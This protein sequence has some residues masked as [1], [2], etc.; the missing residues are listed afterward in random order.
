MYLRWLGLCVGMIIF[1]A[2]TEITNEV[3]KQDAPKLDRQSTMTSPTKVVRSDQPAFENFIS[4][5]GNR[6]FDGDQPF[7]FI[8]INVPTLLYVEDE[9]TFTETNPIRLPTEFET[10]DVLAAVKEI[11]GQVVRSYS[12]PVRNSSFPED[13]VTY[14]EAPGVFNEDAFQVMDQ[15]VALAGEYDLRLIIPL[16]NNWPW[17]GGRPNYAE[18]RGKDPDAF[19]SDPQLIS[20]FKQT[21]DFVLNRVNTITGVAYKDD[22]TIMAWETGNEMTCPPEW[23]VKI[24]SYLKEVAPQQLTIDGWHAVHMPYEGNFISDYIQPHSINH[25]SIDIVSTHHYEEDPIKMLETLKETVRRVGGKKPIFVGEFGFISTSGMKQVMDYIINEEDIAGGMTWSL[26]RHH[27]NGGWFY[28]TEPLG[29]GLYRAYHWPGFDEG[30][31]YDERD[32]LSA[33]QQSAFEIAG[34]SVPLTEV[35]QAP[36][37]LPSGTVGSLRWKGAAGASGYNIERSTSPSGPWQLISDNIDDIVTP[38]FPLFSDETA[39]IGQ[40]YF[41]RVVALNNAGFS[42]AS[43]AVGPIAVDYLTLVDE[44]RN[45]GSMTNWRNIA[46]ETGDFRSYKEA[47][48]RLKAGRDSE[49]I[50]GG[51]GVAKEL[52]LY[53]F[54]RDEAAAIAVQFSENGKDWENVEV[55]PEAYPWNEYGA[56]YPTPKLYRILVPDVGK[57][58]FLKLTFTAEVSIIRVELD[59]IPHAR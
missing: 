52:R 4:R 9:M 39:E 29:G 28:H 23:A 11:G 56:T 40:S 24:T 48:Y 5:K 37:M 45:L 51:K 47:T 42:E 18:F 17:H 13:T 12:I 26:R 7:R 1:S 32:L 14:V 31:A 19:C 35:P 30:E 53:A 58:Q 2:C 20:D 57:A 54:E 46:V 25:P 38:G 27:E 6:L 49:L 34:K 33:L 36:V 50:Y 10:R 55:R 15:V 8:S 21:I 41:Y 59:Y 22:P 3:S 43:N 16:V 44:A